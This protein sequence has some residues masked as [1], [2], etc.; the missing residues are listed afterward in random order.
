MSSVRVLQVLSGSTLTERRTRALS[1]RSGRHRRRARHPI[2]PRAARAKPRVVRRRARR[3]R[4]RML[5][6]GASIRSRR[7]GRVRKTRSARF[8]I[9]TERRFAGGARDGAPPLCPPMGWGGGHSTLGRIGGASRPHI[10]TTSD[11]PFLGGVFRKSC[12]G[13]R[14]GCRPHDDTHP[15]TPG[16]LGSPQKS[17][18]PVTLAGDRAIPD[19]QCRAHLYDGVECV[20]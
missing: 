3:S 13:C 9:V 12:S 4:R 20:S 5:R 18:A 2:P 7:T 15:L 19:A 11:A 8:R 1:P 16:A 10:C 14:S 17:R 6:R